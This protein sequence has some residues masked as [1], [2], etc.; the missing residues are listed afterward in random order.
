MKICRGL[1][2]FILRFGQVPCMQTVLLTVCG[3]RW[4]CDDVKGKLHTSLIPPTDL[5]RVRLCCDGWGLSV[6]FYRKVHTEPR[7]SLAQVPFGRVN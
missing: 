6:E 5:L 7:V 3:G 4:L 2:I 1:S